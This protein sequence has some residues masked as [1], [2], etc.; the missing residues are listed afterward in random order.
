[1][2]AP[3]SVTRMPPLSMPPISMGLPQEI[4]KEL[5]QYI[6]DQQLG[7][8]LTDAVAQVCA[9]RPRD[10]RRRLC[11]LLLDNDA[12]PAA[13][14][15]NTGRDSA[16]QSSSATA[17]LTS[18]AALMAMPLTV[19]LFGATG[20]LARKKLFPAL[21][22]LCLLGHLPRHINIVGYG[23]SVVDLPAFVQKQCVNIKEDP[24]LPKAD[25]TARIRF[26]T[27]GYDAAES[28]TRLD[29]GMAAYEDGAAG[30]RLYFLSVPPTVFGAVTEML[31]EH[32]RARA[33]GFT[34]LMIEKPF[35]RDSESF[36]ELDKLTSRHFDESQLFRLDHYLG[37]EVILNIST[38]R[39]G[40]QLFEPVWCSTYVESVQLTF[41]E[42]LG[43]GGRGGYFDK[44]G[45]IRDIIQNHL[46]QA[47]MWLAM[48]PPASL[49]AAAVVAAKVELLRS[50]KALSLEQGATFLGQ[51]VAHGGNPGYLDDETVPAGS[52]CPTFASLV[53]HADTPR[54][55]GVPF[56]FTAAKGMDERVCE[57]RVRFKP[58]A[59]N[60]IVGAVRDR[61][62]SLMLGASD[63]GA[64]PTANELVMR[65]QPDESLY[66]IAVAKEP[67]ITAEQVRKPVV[68]DMNYRSQFKNAYVGDAYERMLLNAALGDQTLF[69]SSAELTEAW[70]IFTPLLHQI[71]A[72]T[73]RPVMHPFGA[74]PAGFHEFAANH[75]VPIRPTWREFVAL[76]PNLCGE[77]RTIFAE[78]DA[79]GDGHLDFAE[80]TELAK[81]FFDGREPSEKSISA[82]FGDLDGDGDGRITV[83]E[84][85][86]G[87]RKM[88]LNFKHAA[89]SWH[90]SLTGA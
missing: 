18:P 16:A 4:S 78:L 69:V 60:S 85:V 73:E 10:A 20:D 9:E 26:H 77:M 87:A 76:H 44:F 74:M 82:I 33:G 63:A 62:A 23:R 42:D 1:L 41:K 3:R 5:A 31:S 89:D 25:F 22:Q 11:E 24:R 28:Y 84:L 21:Y 56:L 39:W 67:G 30:N 29:A 7:P 12:E 71:D 86:E 53:L 27:G 8:M 68:L 90:G 15:A 40:N 6:E 45:I 54:W 36:E 65:V 35:G 43:T 34:R 61:V 79:N 14:R 75:G 81:R 70:R 50:V 57:L 66:M 49:T 37:K 13:K 46:L 64:R 32:C 48:E 51:F 80:V 59:T 83:E 58:H 88:H 2:S 52:T 72:S 19:V 47:F 17:E 38:L 55:R